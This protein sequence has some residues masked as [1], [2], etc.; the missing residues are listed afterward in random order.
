M[1]ESLITK[2]ARADVEKERRHGIHGLA[3]CFKVAQLGVA[4]AISEGL[5]PVVPLLFGLYHDCRRENDSCDPEHGPRAAA[6]ALYHFREGTLMI[7]PAQL[8]LL[9][10]ACRD[11]TKGLSS[12]DPI[13]SACWDADRLDLPRG[14]IQTKPSYLGTNMARELAEYQ[15]DF[16]N[17]EL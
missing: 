8:D 5:D 7:T 9:V 16:Y 6:L 3:H 10:V 2:D 15:L 4:L 13:I 12:D 14:N 17:G 1:L 11:H